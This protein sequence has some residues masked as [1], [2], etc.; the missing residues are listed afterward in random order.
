MTY[1]TILGSIRVSLTHSFDIN[2]SCI[3]S[4]RDIINSIAQIHGVTDVW[5]TQNQ[6]IFVE[7]LLENEEQGKK[8]EEEI[9]K[10]D[11]IEKIRA[12][13]EIKNFAKL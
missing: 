6:Q 7:L 8:I 10:I 11:G 2:N 5:L 12:I 1:D 3:K 13:Y 9:K 4:I